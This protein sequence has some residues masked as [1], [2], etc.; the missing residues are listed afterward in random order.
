MKEIFYYKGRIAPGSDADVIIWNP[1]R[2][3]VISSSTHHQA[4]DFNIFE[5]MEVNYSAKKKNKNIF[6]YC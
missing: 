3:R 6:I 5:G 1:D 2:T 4:Y